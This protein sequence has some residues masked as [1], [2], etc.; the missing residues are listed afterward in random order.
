MFMLKAAVLATV[1]VNSVLADELYQPMGKIDHELNNAAKWNLTIFPTGK[2]LPEGSG[3]V[4]QGAELF[5]S[6]CAACH[7]QNGRGGSAMALTGDVG[8]L[9]SEY[10]EKTVNSFWPYAT[11]LFDYIRR[12]MPPQA[13]F[14][15]TADEAYALSA[16]ILAQDGLVPEDGHLSQQNIHQIQMPN[17]QGFYTQ[18][19]DNLQVMQ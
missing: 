4:R 2:N 18:P 3:S 15:L 7:G 8:S 9:T 1:V 6:Q 16:F 17:Q 11:T 13:P 19:R 12:T 10:P 5:A 14:S